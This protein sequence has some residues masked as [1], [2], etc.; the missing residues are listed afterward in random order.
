MCLTG[1]SILRLSKSSWIGLMDQDVF[2]GSKSF[3]DELK[4]FDS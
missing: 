4:E 2:E 3:G 1:V